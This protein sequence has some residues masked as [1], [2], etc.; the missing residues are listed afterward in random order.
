MASGMGKA[1]GS[2]TCLGIAG[3]GHAWVF[4]APG[5][6]HVTEGFKAPG[7]EH[8][9]EGFKAPGKGHGA[10]GFKAPGKEH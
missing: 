7:K 2:K 6:E 9:A 5:K 4:K 8:G 3:V 10:E 1:T